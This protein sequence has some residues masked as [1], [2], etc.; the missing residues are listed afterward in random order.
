[1]ALL[2][3]EDVHWKQFQATKFRE[4][5]DQE[6]VDEFL[7]EVVETIATLQDQNASLKSELDEVRQQAAAGG[8][9]APSDSGEETAALKAQLETANAQIAEMQTQVQQYQAAA[10]EGDPQAG[11]QIQALQA[12]LAQTQQEAQ[13]ALAQSQAETQQAE[14]EIE[15]LREQLAQAEQNSQAASQSSAEQPEDAT[16]MLALAQRV[17]DEYVRNG[18]QEADQILEDSRLKGDQIVRE[19]N[20]ER[21]RVLEQLESERADL[22]SRVDDLKAFENDYRQK[23]REHLQSLIGQLDA[24]EA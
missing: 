23:V 20:D 17:H 11:E 2:T 13:A 3:A 12:H 10:A 16:S 24:Q 14:A 21:R 7:D 8:V 15:Q 4:G 19:A 9:V 6:E 18:Q 5:Y 22:E 1:M